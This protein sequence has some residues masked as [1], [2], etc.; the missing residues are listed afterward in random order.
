MIL[1]KKAEYLGL[2]RQVL[3]HDPAAADGCA[4]T[5][6]LLLIHVI[7]VTLAQPFTEKKALP[8]RSTKPSPSTFALCLRRRPLSL[9]NACECARDP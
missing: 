7:I 4:P 8:A 6:L 2:W 9:A 3:G 5:T 1:R